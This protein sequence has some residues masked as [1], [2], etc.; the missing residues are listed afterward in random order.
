MVKGNSM[1]AVYT[2]FVAV[3]TVNIISDIDVN[4][5]HTLLQAL[6]PL[7][8]GCK[9]TNIFR[10]DIGDGTLIINHGRM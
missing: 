5:S 8:T 9:N 2:I 10:N 4:V 7:D 6:S 1:Q 3:L